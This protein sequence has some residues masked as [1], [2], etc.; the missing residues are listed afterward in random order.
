MDVDRV[1]PVVVKQLKNPLNTA[2]SLFVA[3]FVGYRVQKLVKIN[4]A[5][6]FMSV[7]VSDHRINSRILLL[8]TQALHRSF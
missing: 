3:K 5:S 1:R 4:S 8:E 7:Q 2:P 6:V